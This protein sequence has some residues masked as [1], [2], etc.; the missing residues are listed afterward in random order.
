M[1]RAVPTAGALPHSPPMVCSRLGR[2]GWTVRRG[3]GGLKAAGQWRGGAVC[4]SVSP[5]SSLKSGR[6]A[7]PSLAS[8][9]IPAA[10]PLPS[11]PPAQMQLPGVT[12]SLSRSAFPSSVASSPPPFL[13]T[14]GYQIK[15]F[16]APLLSSTRQLP[17]RLQRLLAPAR[18]ARSRLPKM[19]KV[20]LP[21]P[22]LFPPNCICRFVKEKR[23]RERREGGLVIMTAQWEIASI[24][25][26]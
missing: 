15:G 21:P 18:A 5:L 4:A 10:T 20:A 24:F 9:W 11:S 25:A 12:P 22:R 17:R 7:A 23:E 2:R 19:Q 6:R 14:T 16:Q 3:K 13:L 8:S 1:C 26:R